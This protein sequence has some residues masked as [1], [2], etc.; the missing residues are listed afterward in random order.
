VVINWRPVNGV[1]GAAVFPPEL[2]AALLSQALNNGGAA[3]F[4]PE[5]VVALLSQAQNNGGTAVP[6]NIGVVAAVSR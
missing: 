1:G 5:L 3:V 6:G 2:V 4:P